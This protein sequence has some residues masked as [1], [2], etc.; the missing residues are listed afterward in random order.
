MAAQTCLC[1]R[2]TSNAEIAGAPLGRFKNDQA[3]EALKKAMETTGKDIRDSADMLQIAEGCA[4]QMHHS[5]ISAISRSPHPE[6]IP[7]LW[8][9][10][11][12]RYD[13]VP[14]TIVHKAA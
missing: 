1:K 9:C 13:G 8:T 14:L 4:D 6:A 12:D 3:P 10:A 7:F 5:A 11:N 2:L